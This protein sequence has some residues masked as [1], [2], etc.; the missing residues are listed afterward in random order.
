M[1]RFQFSLE[2][3]YK[4]INCFNNKNIFEKIA[5]NYRF[6]GV[7]VSTQDSESCDPI[8]SLGRTFV[9]IDQCVDNNNIQVIKTYDPNSILSRVFI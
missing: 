4:S 3:L 8:S 7:M 1:I 2:P 6:Y 9:N 5:Y